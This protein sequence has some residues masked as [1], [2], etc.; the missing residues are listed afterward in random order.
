MSFSS[1]SPPN[2]AIAPV[3]P[4]AGAAWLTPAPAGYDLN[5]IGK[6]VLQLGLNGTMTIV[7]RPELPGWNQGRGAPEEVEASDARR[8]IV[9]GHRVHQGRVI[10]RRGATALGEVTFGPGVQP[11]AMPLS[12]TMQATIGG[13]R[14]DDWL[15][16]EGVEGP[17]TRRWCKLPKLGIVSTWNEIERLMLASRLVLVD[18]STWTIAFVMR[19]SRKVLAAM[20]PRQV[21]FSTLDFGDTAESAA[22]ALEAS[23]SPSPTAN[24]LTDP[25]RSATP[26]AMSAVDAGANARKESYSSLQA[27]SFQTPSAQPQ[28]SVTPAPPVAS[29]ARSRAGDETLPVATPNAPMR[30]PLAPPAFAPA[31]RR[32]PQSID[33]TPAPRGLP[34]MPPAV[35]APRRPLDAADSPPT[36]AS[37]G[38]EAVQAH[39]AKIAAVDDDDDDGGANRLGSTRQLSPEEVQK[40]LAK[41]AEEAEEGPTKILPT[42]DFMKLQSMLQQAVQGAAGAPPAPAPARAPAADEPDEVSRAFNAIA[43]YA[44]SLGPVDVRSE[45]ERRMRTGG[46]LAGLALSGAS[47]SGIVLEGAKIVDLDLTEADLSNAVLTGADL[48]RSRLDGTKLDGAKLDDSNLAEASLQFASLRGASMTGAKLDG[49]NFAGADLREADLRDAKPDSALV[50]ADLTGAR[51]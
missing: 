50:G 2:I 37:P 17:G 13:R 28:P 35:P 45:I 51:R 40:L 18:V 24:P 23:R 32:A 42:E 43:T 6:I 34:P 47:L 3:G 36:L 7:P 10:L 5:A 39:L 38:F 15:V 44:P 48:T 26:G 8:L 9:R 49:A 14:G 33:V 31:M 46:D 30:G 20:V 1:A 16:V 29:A 4:V 12:N 41:P 11:I 19:A 21:T 22:A 27:A 25:G